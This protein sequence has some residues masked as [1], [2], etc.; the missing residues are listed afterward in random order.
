ML[1]IHF[2]NNYV[3][4]AA[5]E[6]VSK[7]DWLG[8]TDPSSYSNPEDFLATQLHI[9]WE[10][11]FEN[12][13]LSGVLSYEFDI[14]NKE[15][16]YLILDTRDI[17]INKIASN[18]KGLLY[19]LG[20]KNKIF[21]TPLK[22]EIPNESRN[23][24]ALTIE[25]EY[26]TDP[27]CSAL[28]WMEPHQTSG[29]KPFLF[30]Q[31]QPIHGRSMYPC[32]DTPSV[33]TAFTAEIIVPKELVALTSAVP[34]QDAPK[35][36]GDKRVY[37][38]EQKIPIPSYLMCI[39][40]GDLQSKKIGSHSTIYAEQEI[41]EKAVADF[42][43][44]EQLI[45]IAEKLFGKYEW[46]VYNLLFLP[47]AYPMSG[48]EHPC[49][50]FFSQELITG[51]KGG[52]DVLAHELAHSWFGN[53]VTNRDWNH[54]WMN[55]GFTRFADRKILGRTYGEEYRQLESIFGWS[56]LKYEAE[57]LRNEPELA[58][59]VVDKVVDP[60][61]CLN[62]IPYEKG[63]AFLYYLEQTV[64]GASVF[65]PFLREYIK[66]YRHQS[67]ESHQ[68][69]EELIS[70]F[71]PEILR[72]VDWEIW[73][74]S[75]GMPPVTNNYSRTLLDPITKLVKRWKEWVPEDRTEVP[76]KKEDLDGLRNIQLKQFVQE[77]FNVGDLGLEKLKKIEE[78]YG[79]HERTRNIADIRARWFQLCG[80]VRWLE[81]VPLMFEYVNAE[82]RFGALKRVYR[83][84]YEWE[85]IREAA[86]KNFNENKKYK[87]FVTVKVISKVL[88]LEL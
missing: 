45:E 71:A 9:K 35:E 21:G 55:E 13:I 87:M 59:L 64:G 77:L 17:E 39:A 56:V 12:K 60:D 20:E 86:I 22:I 8:K 49:I 24:K 40:V 27:N 48:M 54:F 53:L 47:R 18:G 25:I 46:E 61:R 30:S 85:E 52:I 6:S 72:N 36:A 15:A 88:R 78:I 26:K 70:H 66:K 67:I 42:S 50:S 33:K 3:V 2:G 5:E 11:D 75:P 79:M 29:N 41:I 74:H 16:T 28:A 57:N 4:A 7:E 76:F 38:F 14:I 83:E 84:L 81:T 44:V 34:S 10:V 19:K 68:F 63:S 37:K 32:Q 31:N 23:E 65:E 58:K 69:K 80:K 82:G 73:L 43:D 1:H 62:G 51:N